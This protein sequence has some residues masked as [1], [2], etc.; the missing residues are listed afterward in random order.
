MSSSIPWRLGHRRGPAATL[1]APWPTEEERHLRQVAICQVQGPA[2]VVLG[3]TQRRDLTADSQAGSD[4]PG[5][6]MVRRRTGGGAVWVAPGAQAWVDAWIPRDDPLWDDDVV[7]AARFLGEAWRQALLPLGLA[8]D[9]V[10]VH[11]GRLLDGPWSATVCFAGVGPAEVLVDG[12]KLVG[13]A[14]RRTRH[15]AWFHTSA[16][17]RW[18]PAPL[19]A[20]LDAHGW[21]PV[22]AARAEHELRPLALGLG[23]VVAAAGPEVVADAV[24]A[25]VVSR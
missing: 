21:L 15:G 6:V 13:L 2:A 10:T 24:T 16:H 12:R 17:W 14:Q 9:R 7:A 3:S 8:A 25:A 20:A 11:Q 5:P 22:D 18:D 23:D 19:V 4:G 1:L